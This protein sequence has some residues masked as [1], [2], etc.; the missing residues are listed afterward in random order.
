MIRWGGVFIKLGFSPDNSYSRYS[1]GKE[2]AHD[3]RREV[4]TSTAQLAGSRSD[5]ISETHP[6]IL[7]IADKLQ[8]GFNI[9]KNILRL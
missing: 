2:T 3:C 8:I 7:L 5:Q 1:G 6:K 9:K 4:R